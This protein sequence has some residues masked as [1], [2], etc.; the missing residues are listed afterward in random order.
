MYLFDLLRGADIVR[1]D[2]GGTVTDANTGLW[3][4]VDKARVMEQDHGP[5][6][7]DRRPRMVVWCWR[8]AGYLMNEG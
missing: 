6:R 2:C 1:A 4:T 5:R 8:V 3:R 7:T